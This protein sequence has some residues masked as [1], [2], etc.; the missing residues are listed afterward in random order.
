[1]PPRCSISDEPNAHGL[2]RDDDTRFTGEI[3]PTPPHSPRPSSLTLDP[4]G[5]LRQ[6]GDGTAQAYMR[7]LQLACE[8]YN[9]CDLFVKYLAKHSPA[10]GADKLLHA[11]LRGIHAQNHCLNRLHGKNR[12]FTANRTCYQLRRRLLLIAPSDKPLF[13]WKVE[14]GSEFALRRVCTLEMSHMRSGS[15]DRL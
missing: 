5:S 1:M 13:R 3:K 12:N 2:D 10:F 4:A 14:L 8:V 9:K 11:R 6:R 15:R 7:G